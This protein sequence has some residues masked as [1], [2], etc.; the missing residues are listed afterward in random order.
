LA[1]AVDQRADGALI[2]IDSEVSGGQNGTGVAG[3]LERLNEEL[4]EIASFLRLGCHEHLVVEELQELGREWPRLD[5]IGLLLIGFGN[6]H[7]THAAR[8]RGN[9]HRDSPR[10]R[11][12]EC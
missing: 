7:L 11:S 2:A 1:D 5:E 4:D 8:I 6:R 9:G 10:F 3:D 12:P